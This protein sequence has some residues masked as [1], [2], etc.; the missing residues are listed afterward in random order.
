MRMA[1]QRQKL[2]IQKEEQGNSQGDYL[3]RLEGWDGIQPQWDPGQ[4]N[5]QSLLEQEKG[6]AFTFML[7]AVATGARWNWISSPGFHI[8]RETG[9]NFFS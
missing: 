8:L 9:S 4:G 1:Q 5:E 7:M 2:L 6:R 3:R